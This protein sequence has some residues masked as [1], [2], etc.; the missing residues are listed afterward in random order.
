L[1][2]LYS[3]LFKTSDYENADS[4]EKV[5]PLRPVCIRGP[6]SIVIEK[7]LI[8]RHPELFEIAI[9][10]TSRPPRQDDSSKYKYHFSPAFEMLDDIRYGKFI[11][12][13]TEYDDL[14]GL[15]RNSVKK[16]I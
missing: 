2:Q 15:S 14:Y 1:K 10:T 4:Q 13:S 6:L 12:Y 5:G 9:E 11:E 7:A 3:Y 8:K 16:V